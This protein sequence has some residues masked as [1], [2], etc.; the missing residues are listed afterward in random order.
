MRWVLLLFVVLP[1][2]ELWLLLVIGEAIGLWPTVAIALTTGVLGGSL[3]KREGM[4]VWRA[5]LDALQRM[6]PPK[7]GVIDGLLVLVGGALLVTPGVIT[8]V[9]GLLLL[10]P[11]TRRPIAA[12]VRAA[13]D[14]RIERSSGFRVETFTGAESPFPG[15]DPFASPDVGFAPTDPAKD[16]VVDTSG[17]DVTTDESLGKLSD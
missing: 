5:W 16:A 1:L 3:A 6:V 4:R 9:T 7:E 2:T 11:W 17:T 13:V 10:I 12:R 8:D 15:A 14:R